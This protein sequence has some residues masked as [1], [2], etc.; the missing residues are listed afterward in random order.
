MQSE[1]DN[2]ESAEIDICGI[3]SYEVLTLLPL[4][5]NDCAYELC[6]ECYFENGGEDYEC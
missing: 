3:C 4:Q 5:I 2:V 1:N 6:S